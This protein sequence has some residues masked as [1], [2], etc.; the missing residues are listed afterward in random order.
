MKRREIEI[1]LRLKD[2]AEQ[3]RMMVQL[4]ELGFQL[5][6]SRMELDYSVDTEGY[7]CRAKGLIVRLRRV[8]EGGHR[9]I[10]L[11]FKRKCKNAN[12]VDAEESEMILGEPSRQVWDYVNRVLKQEVGLAL[13]DGILGGHD[14]V[15]VVE[16]LFQNGFSYFRIL[17][18]KRRSQ[19]RRGDVVATLDELP[20]GIGRFMELEAHNESQLKGLMKELGLSD[21]EMLNMDYGDLIMEYNG[22]KDLAG[23]TAVFDEEVK[24]AVYRLVGF[25]AG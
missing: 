11:T 23:R 19:L 18:E 25:A 2:E 16:Q 13:P 24:R 20:N 8:D 5:E 21:N 22:A 1:K 7:R 6:Y 9:R 17:L 10:I 14:F 15:S 4:R 12:F 3:G